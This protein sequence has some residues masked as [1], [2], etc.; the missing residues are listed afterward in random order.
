MIAN[1][2]LVGS[3]PYGA[4]GKSVN[5]NPP[6]IPSQGVAHV[7]GDVAVA[8][9]DSFALN[10]CAG[11]HR[12]E[13]DTRHFMHISFVGALEPMG[14]VNDRELIGV[15]TAPDDA[16]ALSNFLRASISPGGD[17]YEDFAQ[18]L[19]TKRVDLKNKPGLRACR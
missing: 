11:C 13:T 3:A 14:K 5:P 4:W 7:L 16:V 17:R 15:A 10:T 18:L 12:H 6:T 8:V 19:V 2:S 1:A 9:R